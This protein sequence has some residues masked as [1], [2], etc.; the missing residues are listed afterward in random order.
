MDRTSV[1]YNRYNNR[2][3]ISQ[4]P[5]GVNISNR[6]NQITGD[7]KQKKKKHTRADESVAAIHETTALI[8]IYS[9]MN[10]PRKVVVLE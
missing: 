3:Y 5:Q 7:S 9:A 4:E 2:C 8:A 10:T 6:V 1:L